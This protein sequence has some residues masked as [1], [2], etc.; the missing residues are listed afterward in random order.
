MGYCDLLLVIMSYCGL[1]KNEKTQYF[2]CCVIASSRVGMKMPNFL[3]TF[4][5]A[6]LVCDCCKNNS[7]NIVFLME[8]I[9]ESFHTLQPNGE[10]WTDI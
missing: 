2:R 9:E 5:S 6:F 3:K 4:N 7:V 10:I 8:T 1:N